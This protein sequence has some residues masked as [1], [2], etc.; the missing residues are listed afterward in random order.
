MISSDGPAGE[1]QPSGQGSA[2]G[3]YRKEGTHLNRP[4]YINDRNTMYLY[5]DENG[6]WR[7]G[8]NFTNNRIMTT[9]T[10]LDNPPTGAGGWEFWNSAGN[11][12]IS[13]SEITVSILGIILLVHCT[14]L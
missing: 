11:N 5:N 2:M 8:D 10:W 1:E 6:A 4:Y 7:I 9:E 14:V 13:D 3:V 12:Y